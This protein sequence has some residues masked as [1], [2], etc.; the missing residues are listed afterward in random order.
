MKIQIKI[1]TAFAGMTTVAE[2]ELKPAGSV[3]GVLGAA[4]FHLGRGGFNYPFVEM[5]LEAANCLLRIH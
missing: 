1:G 2:I 3:G 5:E 4:E